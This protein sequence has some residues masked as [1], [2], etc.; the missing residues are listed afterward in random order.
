MVS[1][2]Y[3]LFLFAMA[4][5]LGFILGRTTHPTSLNPS[6]DSPSTAVATTPGLDTAYQALLERYETVTRTPLAK[7]SY[8]DR[9]FVDRAT[10]EYSTECIPITLADSD[11][12]PFCRRFHE[13]LTAFND[14]NTR[15]RIE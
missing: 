3:A 10:G 5:F 15:D 11:L 13:A 4:L 8:D 6:K 1:K 12:E 9:L 7:L 14:L 2:R